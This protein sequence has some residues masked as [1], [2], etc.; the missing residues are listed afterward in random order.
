[1]LVRPAHSR[2]EPATTPP[3][4]PPRAQTIVQVSIGRVEVK[5]APTPAVPT[6]VTPAPAPAEKSG[7]RLT[8]DA[9]LERVSERRRR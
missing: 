7:P 2:T 6:P 3:P 9:F 5:A 1:M 4:V 8:L